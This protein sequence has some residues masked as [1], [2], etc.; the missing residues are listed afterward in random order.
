MRGLLNEEL[1][2]HGSNQEMLLVAKASDCLGWDSCVKGRIATQWLP[3]VTPLLV[4]PSPHLLAKL[5]GRQLII[6]LHNLIHTQ[7]VYWN[8]VI[9]Y[10]GKDGFTI[11]N[12]HNILNQMEE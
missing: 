2:R 10:E 3:T 7:W 9:H 5:W 8:S 6:K 12:H 1:C 11:P 4:R